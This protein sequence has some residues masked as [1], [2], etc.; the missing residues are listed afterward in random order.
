[1]VETKAMMLFLPTRPPYCSLGAGAMTTWAIKDSSGQTLPG[2]LGSSRI[3]VG[4]KV[5]PAR[6]DA[7]RLHVSASYRELFDRALQQ[8]LQRNGWE[9]VQLSPT[10]TC[11]VGPVH[12]PPDCQGRCESTRPF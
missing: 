6:Y 8:V 3:E 10:T 12:A 7:F 5:M 2:F 1:M 4:C 11:P 9:I